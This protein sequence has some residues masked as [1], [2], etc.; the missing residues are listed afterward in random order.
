MPGSIRLFTIYD[1]VIRKREIMLRNS[2]RIPIFQR[3]RW[4]YERIHY[5]RHAKLEEGPA[6]GGPQIIIDF[7]IGLESLRSESGSLREV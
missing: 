7:T 5:L 3:F 6:V 2:K 1:L 4:P